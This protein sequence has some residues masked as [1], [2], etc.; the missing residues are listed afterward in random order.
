MGRGVREDV[1]REMT[2]EQKMPNTMGVLGTKIA[3]TRDKRVRPIVRPTVVSV[4]EKQWGEE[5]AEGQEAAG[6]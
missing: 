5:R 6:H 3:T 2:P 1:S 4:A